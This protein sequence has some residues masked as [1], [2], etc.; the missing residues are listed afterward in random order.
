MGIRSLFLFIPV[1][2]HLRGMSF[3][4]ELKGRSLLY[5]EYLCILSHAEMKFVRSPRERNYCMKKNLFPF[6]PLERSFSDMLKGKRLLCGE[7]SCFLSLVNA[8]FLK[9][10]RGTR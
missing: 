5:R 2:F 7:V 10:L 1:S 8:V 6:S 3:L 9:V 4:I